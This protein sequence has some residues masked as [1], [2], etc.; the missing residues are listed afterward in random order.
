MID[1]QGWKDEIEQ[2]LV[3]LLCVLQ[4]LTYQPRAV[5]ETIFEYIEIQKFSNSRFTKTTSK[6]RVQIFQ[7]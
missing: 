4:T 7:P 1:K 2:K 6:M 3:I 5:K